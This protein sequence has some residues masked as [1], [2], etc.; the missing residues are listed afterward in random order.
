MKR[1]WPRARACNSPPKSAARGGAGS[2]RLFE[3]PHELRELADSLVRCELQVLAE[4]RAID[5]LLERIDHRI[6]RQDRRTPPQALGHGLNLA[7]FR[8]RRITALR[9]WRTF[10]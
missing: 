5:V 1:T 10:C 2:A 4:E 8:H 9:A 3:G 6:R 7:P